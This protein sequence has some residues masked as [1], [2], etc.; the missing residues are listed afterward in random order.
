VNWRLALQALLGREKPGQ[1]GTWF[2]P[3]TQSGQDV[4]ESSALRYSAFWGCVRVIS[5]TSATLPWQVLQRT[6]NGRKEVDSDVAWM[7]AIQPNPEMSPFVFKELM[8]RRAAVCGNAYAEI[9]R[10]NAGRPVALWPILPE[11]VYP[12]RNEDGQLV[13]YVRDMDQSEVELAAADVFHLKGPGGDGLVGYS[14][15]QMAAESVG[16]GLAMQEFGASFF[17]NGAHVGGALF[18]PKTLSDTARKN[19]EQSVA[20]STGRKNALSLRVF[21]EGM[22]YERIGIP[23]EDAQF[24]ES[25]NTQVRDI[26]RWF[27]VPPHKVADLADAKWANIEWQSIDFVTDAIVPWVCRME[28]EANAKL[29]GRNNRNSIYTRLNIAALLRGD[30][31]ARYDS[32]AVG[33]QW[34]FLS[35]NDIRSLEDMNPIANG[36]LYIVPS[37]MMTLAQLKKG[38]QPTAPAPNANP[39]E[40]SEETGDEPPQPKPRTNCAAR[41][42]GAGHA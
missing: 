38:P 3:R 41:P 9:E 29:F 21:E 8:T 39:A 23:P 12:R 34:S 30:M 42:N 4:D 13:Y 20:K 22:T 15:I 37:N 25:R 6:K 36:D 5:E 7:L 40:P 32:Y 2:F 18:H 27:R 14:V 10:D 31:K 35:A 28:Q 33:R 24:L 11:R 16:L 26:C 17:G 1:T 19:L